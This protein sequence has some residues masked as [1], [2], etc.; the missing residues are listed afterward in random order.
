MD[1]FGDGAINAFDPVTGTLLGALQD[2]TGAAIHISA[3]W[4]SP[5]ETAAVSAPAARL[6]AAM[7]IR[8]TSQPASRGRIPRVGSAARKHSTLLPRLQ[9]TTW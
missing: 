2:G 6:P 7:P 3:F 8:F 5:S 9:P 1:N 4:D